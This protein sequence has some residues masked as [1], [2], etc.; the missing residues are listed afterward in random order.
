MSMP[1]RPHPPADIYMMDNEEEYWAEGCQSWF[2]ATVRCDVND[3]IN[4]REALEAH[5]PGLAQAL[6]AAFGD[7]P[8]RYP[9]TA[10]APL[11]DRA[12][13]AVVHSPRPAG[14]AHVALQV[15]VAPPGAAGM[16]RTA[17]GGAAYRQGCMS[18]PVHCV[19]GC[20]SA[21]RQLWGSFWG[22][23]QR[24]GPLTKMH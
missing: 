21:P 8:W 20:W 1:P 16:E 6:R 19:G 11:R 17:V 7:N 13:R 9:H 12:G 5:D 15:Q 2:D 18:G 14:R 4:R 23:G 10:P 24:G 22:R 3:G